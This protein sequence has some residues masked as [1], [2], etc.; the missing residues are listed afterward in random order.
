MRR[1]LLIEVLRVV[2][3]RVRPGSLERARQAASLAYEARENPKLF[4]KHDFEIIRGVIEAADFL[5]ALWLINALSGIYEEIARMLS[6][7]TMAPLDYLQV[8]SV[9]FD[10]L[11]GG[12]ALEACELM[13]NYFVRH[14]ERLLSTL[15]APS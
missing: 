12:R 9:A 7:V 13:Q 11:E 10:A 5:P 2:G 6:G 4:L 14:A 1:A 15:G 8:H 3:H